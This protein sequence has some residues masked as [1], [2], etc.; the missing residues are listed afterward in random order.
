MFDLECGTGFVSIEIAQMVGKTGRLIASD[1]QE[2]M[3]Q[4]MRNRIIDMEIVVF[5]AARREL[6]GVEGK[7]RQSF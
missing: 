6:Q 4:K 5:E 1:L 3:L 7:L 2:E